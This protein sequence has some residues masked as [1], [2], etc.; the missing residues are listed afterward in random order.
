V[1]GSQHLDA[2]TLDKI[3]ATLVER[4]QGDGHVANGAAKLA[5]D[6]ARAAVEVEPTDPDATPL[7][8]MTPEERIALYT[9]LLR[10]ESDGDEGDD[11]ALPVPLEQRESP[12]GQAAGRPL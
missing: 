6:L 11:P 2:A 4:A 12:S 5:L 10:D 8:S 3:F 7:E 1:K 9:A